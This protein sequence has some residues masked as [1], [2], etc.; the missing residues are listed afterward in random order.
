MRA[1]KGRKGDIEWE[2]VKTGEFVKGKIVDVEVEEN[3]KFKAFGEGEDTYA[4]ACRF[5]FQLEG[6]EHNHKSRWMKLSMHEKSNFY[7]K[8]VEELVE[9]ADPETTIVD[10]EDFKGMEVKTLWKEKNG[11]QW[12]EVVLPAVAHLKLKKESQEKEESHEENPY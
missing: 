12:P 7:K 1:P 2:M 6:Y 3:H 11:F 8:Y 5:V 9:D 4:L 10:T